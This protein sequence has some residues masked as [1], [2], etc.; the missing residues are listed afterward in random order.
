MYSP[1]T[2]EVS[3]TL[4]AKHT[5]LRIDLNLYLLHLRL[6]TLSLFKSKSREDAFASV[7][8]DDVEPTFIGGVPDQDDNKGTSADGGAE[9]TKKSRTRWARES[10]MAMVRRRSTVDI[11]VEEG[12]EEG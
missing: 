5:P 6:P 8:E 2:F 9:P 1:P 10:I 11:K 12:K 7:H 4:T 3:L